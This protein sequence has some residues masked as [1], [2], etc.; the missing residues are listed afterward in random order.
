MPLMAYFSPPLPDD[1]QAKSEV[2]SGLAVASNDTRYLDLQ[3]KADQV[4]INQDGKQAV[5]RGEVV[6]QENEPTPT[7]LWVLAVA[8][9]SNGD[10]VGVR[11]WKSVGETSFEITAYSMAGLIDHVEVLTEGRP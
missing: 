4:E 6:L 11:K 8:Y 1:F 3:V 2:L 10:I 7:Q 5:I 9:D